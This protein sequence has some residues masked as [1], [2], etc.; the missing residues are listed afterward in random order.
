M[1][2]K[3]QPKLYPTIVAFILITLLI[4][5][6]IYLIHYFTK[7]D[8]LEINFWEDEYVWYVFY[9]GLV[10]NLFLFSTYYFSETKTPLSYIPNV[11][12]GLGVFFTFIVIWKKLSSGIKFD[13][14]GFAALVKNL[15]AAFSTSIVGIAGSMISSVIL[16]MLL[17][18]E[19]YKQEKENREAYA[20]PEMTLW[21]LREE[22]NQHFIKITESFRSNNVILKNIYD[23]FYKEIQEHKQETQEVKNLLSHI[24]ADFKE[25]LETLLE[26]LNNKLQNVI[27]NMGNE[28]LE[29]SQK[30]IEELNKVLKEVM[31]NLMNENK[32]QLDENLTQLKNTTDVS[33]EVLSSITTTFNTKLSEMAEHYKANAQNIEGKFEN[34][35]NQFNAMNEGMQKHYEENATAIQ[36]KF[37]ELTDVF[38]KF[39][40]QIQNAIDT[41]LKEGVEGLEKTFDRI[42]E[43][44]LSTKTELETI[45][46]SFKNAVEEYTA[47]KD[48]NKGIIDELRTQT[49]TLQ[50]LKEGVANIPEYDTKIAEMQNRISDIGNAIEKLGEIKE[51]LTLKQN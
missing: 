5:L 25:Q 42:K 44:Q 11:W 50:G 3:K 6:A 34:V 38:S 27:G 16:K 26:N 37:Q 43:W 28:A 1:I 12:T 49:E 33:K 29:K 35:A 47:F 9:I 51:L 7:S 14:E 8:K 15:T 40:E 48:A 13:E 17:S 45:S 2:Y 24:P 10:I 30:N 19:E 21:H 20:S 23:H 22:S 39:D 31:I 4:L 46:H 36:G 32:K 41:T 18:Y